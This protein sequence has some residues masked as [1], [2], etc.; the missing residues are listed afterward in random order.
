[1]VT[2]ENRE[3]A[4]E[5]KYAHDEEFR[6]RVIARR[7]KLVAA[8]AADRLKLSASATEELTGSVLA[9]RD[10]AGHDALLVSHLEAQFSSHSA[11]VPVTEINAALTRCEAEAR[12]QLLGAQPGS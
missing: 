3:Q 5:A 7:D 8:W 6:F 4:F 10:G 1:M 12:Q 9:V 2:F 11:S